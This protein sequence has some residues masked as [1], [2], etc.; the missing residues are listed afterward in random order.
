MVQHLRPDLRVHPVPGDAGSGEAKEEEDVDN[1]E[2]SGE[3]VEDTLM[4]CWIREHVEEG[5]VD[6]DACTGMW[7]V[8]ESIFRPVRDT[9]HPCSQR[10]KMG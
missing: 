10:T 7:R 6:P 8:R 2:G 3:S 9:I 1:Q 5:C 4:S